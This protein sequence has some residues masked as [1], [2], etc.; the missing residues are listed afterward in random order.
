MTAVTSTLRRR[1]RTAGDRTARGALVVAAAALLAVAAAAL[2][3]ATGPTGVGLDALR[4][5]LAGGDLA[6]R[7]RLVLEAVRLPRTGLA[8]LVGAGLA[9]SGA[10]MQGLF[11]NPLA[12]PG[13]VGVSAGAATAAVATIVLGGALPASVAGLLGSHLLPLAAFAGGLANTALLYAL[14]T[15]GGRTSTATLIL[16][17]IA[18]S[19]L[20]GALTGLLIFGAD[21]AALRDVT[22]WSLGSLGAATAPKLAAVAPFVLAALAAGPFVARGLDALLLGEAEAVHLGVPVQRLKRVA[23][24]AVAAANGA[25][26]AVTGTIG[27]VGIVVPHLLRLLMGPG[28]R[29]LL[30]A[31]AFGGAALL[32]GADALCRIVVAPAELP[33]GIVTA[34]LGAPVFLAI[35][36]RRPVEEDRP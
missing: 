14:A 32:L 36:L 34:L 16:A 6:D 5:W 2:S 11:R 24:T 27:F 9:V 30:P 26:V 20:A 4:T 17:G 35:L 33:V 23:I 31:C 7:Q 1:P 10:I 12:D 19:A 28:H 22:F 8:A 13:L 15:R 3:L 18:V 25:T 21:D 29:L